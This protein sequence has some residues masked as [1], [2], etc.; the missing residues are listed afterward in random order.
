V[1]RYR[2]FTKSI[3]AELEDQGIEFR[4]IETSVVDAVN[5]MKELESLLAKV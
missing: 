3:Q 5:S 2:Q 1:S 4:D